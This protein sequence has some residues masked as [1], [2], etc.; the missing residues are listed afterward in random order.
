MAERQSTDRCLSNIK[1]E[2]CSAIFFFSLCDVEE[3]PETAPPPDGKSLSR[4]DR[5]Y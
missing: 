1:G 5:I 2:L 3:V 4:I